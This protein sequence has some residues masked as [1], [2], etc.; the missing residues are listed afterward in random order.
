MK[1]FNKQEFNSGRWTGPLLKVLSRRLAFSDKQ[2]HA[3]LWRGESPWKQWIQFEPSGF[4]G[5]PAYWL[6][7][8]AILS[9]GQRLFAGYYIERGYPENYHA[10]LGY[11]GSRLEEKR[12]T[13]ITPGW[14]WHPFMAALANAERRSRLNHIMNTLPASRRCI[15]LLNNQQTERLIPYEGEVSL[16]DLRSELHNADSTFYI[17]LIM[18]VYFT[19]DECL[20]LQD[21]IVE[22]LRKPLVQANEID[23]LV[24]SQQPAS[25]A[26]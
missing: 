12:Q 18:G 24:L 8:P 13:E 5:G 6:G 3:R 10:Q 16:Q 21:A 17:D 19:V 1:I 4:P 26:A 20:E 15:W 2:C 14:H 9:C 22:E 7:K 23:L 25:A 11:Q